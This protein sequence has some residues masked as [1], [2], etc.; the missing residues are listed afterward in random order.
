MFPLSGFVINISIVSF[1]KKMRL[2][3]P[4]AQVEKKWQQI[5]SHEIWTQR[6]AP[7]QRIQCS[8]HPSLI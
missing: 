6:L 8:D 7:L 4:S 2:K 1:Q 5:H 3:P